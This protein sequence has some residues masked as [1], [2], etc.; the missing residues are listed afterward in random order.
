MVTTRGPISSTHRPA[1]APDRAAHPARRTTTTAGS[2]CARGAATGSLQWEPRVGPRDATWPRTA[3]S[4]AARCALRERERQLGTGF[5]FGIFVG[6]R[7]VGELTLSSIRAGPSRAPTSATGSTRRW[8]G[9]GLRARGGR[10]VPAASRSSRCACTASR[11][12][13]IPSNVASRRVVEKLGLRFEGVAERLPVDRRRVGGPRPLRDHR[14]GVGRPRPELVADWLCRARRSQTATSSR[15][16]DLVDEAVRSRPPS[17]AARPARRC[18]PLRGRTTSA[19]EAARATASADD[20]G[21]ERASAATRRRPRRRARDSTT[22]SRSDVRRS[23][24]RS[25]EHPRP[26]PAPTRTELPGDVEPGHAARPR[27]RGRAGRRARGA[28]RRRRSPVV[29]SRAR[30]AR[31]RAGAEA[32]ERRTACRRGRPRRAR[33]PRG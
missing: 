11:S 5:G 4:F 8:A 21:V 9:R 7:F 24:R 25:R 13:I 30:P 26:S 20:G 23:A 10:G 6:G 1:R 2:R 32:L 29:W 17:P 19:S 22:G 31:G 18:A 3:R 12:S 33:A 27:R 28:R 15:R 14:R 16:R